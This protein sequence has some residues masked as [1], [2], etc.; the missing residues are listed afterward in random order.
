[1]LFVLIL[2]IIGC[3]I[4]NNSDDKN[5]GD[6]NTWIEL[7]EVGTRYYYN[8]MKGDE[9][10][11]WSFKV[12]SIETDDVDESIIYVHE[13]NDTGYLSKRC[14]IIRNEENF[15]VHS[16][17]NSYSNDDLIFIDTPVEPTHTWIN[18]TSS[19]FTI[20]STG[21]NITAEGGTFDDCVIIF[22]DSYNFYK[23]YYSP[24]LPGIVYIERVYGYAVQDTHYAELSKITI[25]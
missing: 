1:M 6:I 9:S 19:D 23:Y 12:D 18:G 25:E 7:P 2:V 16:Y 21:E 17:D 20:E 5:T 24:S 15:A 22:V 10:D 14:I 4:S 11:T 3:S 8:I 13:R